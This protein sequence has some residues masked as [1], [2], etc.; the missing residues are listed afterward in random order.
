MATDPIADAAAI[1]GICDSEFG[2]RLDTSEQELA[3]QVALGACADAG[4]EAS[5][6]D[7]MVSYDIESTIDTTMS[8]MLGTGDLSF[9]ANV[10]YGGG[11]APGA[12]GL[13]AMAIAT[14]RCHVGLV[15]RSRKRG[16]GGRPWRSAG[17]H[18]LTTVSAEFTRPAGIVRPVDEIAMLARR[19]MHEYGL[20]REQ[21]AAVAI[22]LR[23]HANATPAAVMHER[24][25]ELDDYMTSR[26]VSEPLCLYDNCLET[27]GASAVIMVSA[28]RAADLRRP[29]V[30]VHAATQ[31]MPARM[32]NQVNYFNDDPMRTAGYACARHL[33]GRSELTPGDIDV[34][35]IYDA[36]TPLVLWA[37]EAYGF[38][39]VGE[40]GAFVAEGAIAAGGRLPVNTA[41]GS[42]SGA[43][44]HGFNLVT[45]GVRQ[46]RG[47]AS[48]Q[49]AGATTCLVTG[50]ESVPSSAVILRRG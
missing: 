37:L 1:A 39:E 50:A 19:Y 13:M 23:R 47:H 16:S 5:E 24:T 45:E 32:A 22:T 30:L 42:L 34:V 15:W 18:R 44:I 38:C 11:A 8:H 4:I 26:W 14:G 48:N 27:D 25:L 9:F 40:A 36:F 28:E 12:L 35:Q 7:G 2:R 33:Y 43:Y 29:V 21:L 49:V 6:I 31:G 20:T 17:R 46:L 10:G 41:G 3:S